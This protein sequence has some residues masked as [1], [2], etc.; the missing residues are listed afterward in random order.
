FVGPFPEPPHRVPRM[1]NV[2]LDSRMYAVVLA[3]AARRAGVDIRTGTAVTGLTTD[4]DGR[5]VGAL[6]E[7]A[8]GPLAIRARRG[9]VLAAGDFSGNAGMRRSYLS[10]AAADS[11]PANPASTGIGQRLGLELGAALRGMAVSTGP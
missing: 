2:V 5:V 10:P 1:H 8:D 9:V 3:R 7:T 11:V 6:A 4:A